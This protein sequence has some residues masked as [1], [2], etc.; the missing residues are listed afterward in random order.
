VP[1]WLAQRSAMAA[2]GEH[3]RALVNIAGFGHI[4]PM[5]HIHLERTFVFIASDA[6]NATL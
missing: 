4:W 5:A 6:G 3:H 1:H 2:N